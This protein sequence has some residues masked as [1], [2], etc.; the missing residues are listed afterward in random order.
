MRIPS[1]LAFAFVAAL[2]ALPLRTAAQQQP[3]APAAAPAAGGH[4]AQ[5]PAPA[6]QQPTFRTGVDIVSVDVAVVDSRGNPVED[7]RAPDFAVKIDGE[8]RRVVSAELVKVDVE[9]ARRQT[10][11]KTETLLYQQPHARQRPPHRHRRRSDQHL[12]RRAAADHGRGAAVPRSAE[13]ARPGGVH[14]LSRAGPAR[15]LHHRQAEAAAGDAG[16]DRPGAARAG[17]AAEHRRHRG[18]GDLQPPRSDRPRRRGRARMPRPERHGA[19]AVRARH[20]HA[21]GGDRAPGS[22][23]RR[24]LGERPAPACCRSCPRSRVTSR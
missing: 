10:A 17:G 24:L 21:V 14:R 20:H 12:A 4:P 5:E 8:V 23:G 7:L 3:P 2:A 22:R 1:W 11:D 15:E 6:S 19:R 16:A 13:P 18:A 9:A